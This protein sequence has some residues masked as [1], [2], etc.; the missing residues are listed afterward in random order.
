MA[1]ING[2]A[3]F[4]GTFTPDGSLTDFNGKQSNGLWELRI[5]DVAN[6]GNGGTLQN[7]EICLTGEATRDHS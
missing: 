6:G 4:T 1:I 3:P 2:A 7:W 5:Y